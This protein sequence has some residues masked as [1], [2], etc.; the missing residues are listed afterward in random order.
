L[1]LCGR[2]T[3]GVTAS[4]LTKYLKENFGISS[5][6]ESFDVPRFNITPGQDIVTI[7]AAREGFHSGY[8]NW[9]Y[10]FS[11]S[12]HGLVNIRSESLKEKNTFLNSFQQRR[13]LVIADGF[14]EWK[15]TDGKKKA[16]WIRPADE[17]IF[18]MAGLWIPQ[19]EGK[20][21]RFYAAIVTHPAGSKME[22]IHH[23][24]P[25]I[26]TPEEGKV[27]LDRQT[28]E[29]KLTELLR[30]YPEKMAIEPVS[31]R[32]NDPGIDDERCIWRED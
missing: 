29:E 31:S 25:V 10:R 27:W 26:F 16:Y 17:T 30:I 1:N 14:Y 12:G 8:L 6:P 20:N 11:T 15:T 4:K 32:V 7:I 28:G 24:M 18:L 21:K 3:L 5:N 19:G 22:S 2:F 13:C 23:R 9:N